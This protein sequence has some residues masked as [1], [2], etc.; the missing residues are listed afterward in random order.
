VKEDEADRVGKNE[1]NMDIDKILESIRDPFCIIDRNY[2]IVKMNN[3]Y[4]EAKGKEEEEELIGKRCY[5][6]L[7][8]RKSICDDCVVE[9]AFVSGDPCAKVK[10]VILPDGSEGWQEIY[11]YPIISEERLVTHVIEYVRDITERKKTERRLG[12]LLKEVENIN[13]ELKDFAYIVSHDL[14]APLRAISSLAT[15]LA[16]DY[17]DRLGEEGREH[18]NLLLNRVKRMNNLIDGILQYSRVGHSKE[19]KVNVDLNELVAEVIDTLSPPENIEIR[20]ENKLPVIYAEDTRVRQ[21]FQNLLSNAIKYMDK[22]RGLVRINCERDGD[23]WKFSVSDNGPGIEEK[24][25]GK[26]FQ[27]FQTLDRRDETEATGIG[28]ALIKR[29]IDIYGGSIWVESELGKGSTFFF[30]LPI[31]TAEDKSDKKDKEEV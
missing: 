19:E 9:K 11:T 12:Q 24:Y 1:G 23:Y 29:I 26:I 28:L 31:S 16:S 30:T 20:V 22:P 2:I 3:A 21:I 13:Q 25:F 10:H 7:Y 27:L 4:L 5:E 14:K 15:W 17:G 6:V 18:L 8:D